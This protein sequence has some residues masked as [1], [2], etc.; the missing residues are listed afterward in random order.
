MLSPAQVCLNVSLIFIPS[1]SVIF[2]IITANHYWTSLVI[3]T[4]IAN[5][6]FLSTI[7]GWAIH[8]LILYCITFRINF[9]KSVDKWICLFCKSPNWTGLW[10]HSR[11]EWLPGVGL[12]SCVQHSTSRPGSCNLSCFQLGGDNLV[13][14]SS[15]IRPCFHG[16]KLRVRS[17]PYF[18]AL[19][20]CMKF[21]APPNT[22]AITPNSFTISH[23]LHHLNFLSHVLSSL[24][25]V[26]SIP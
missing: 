22:F 4:F 12:V 16:Y 6:L 13:S 19:H 11:P 10:L 25:L 1:I 23:E 18:G 14:S 26:V 3:A 15:L 5:L 2:L 20:P 7:S 17:S 9:W 8:Q 24:F 21:F